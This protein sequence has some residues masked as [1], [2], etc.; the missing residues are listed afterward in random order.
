MLPRLLDYAVNG[1]QIE[2]KAAEKLWE[3]IKDVFASSLKTEE[4]K[5]AYL[6]IGPII[7][8]ILKLLHTAL[9]KN[10]YEATRCYSGLLLLHLMKTMKVL[11]KKIPTFNV[12][13]Q[14]YFTNQICFDRILRILD[15]PLFKNDLFS[16]H[17][18][19]DAML[20]DRE[21]CCQKMLENWH[22][23]PEINPLFLAYAIIKSR[24]FNYSV[25]TAEQAFADAK[26]IM[27]HPDWQYLFLLQSERL[28]EKLKSHTLAEAKELLEK[29]KVPFK[30]VE[31]AFFKLPLPSEKKVKKMIDD[32]KM[33]EALLEIQGSTQSFLPI[34][35]QGMPRYKEEK[36]EAPEQPVGPTVENTEKITP[37]AEPSVQSS[38]DE[39]PAPA[40][41][42]AQTRMRAG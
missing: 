41:T 22:K 26:K 4:E 30:P 36:T 39:R 40:Y 42:P 29:I 2:F 16:L 8:E 11:N 14:Y 23:L 1:G 9:K 31:C 25:A 10:H 7:Q 15:Q 19:F 24:E 21:T 35:Q 33:S 27:K 34:L 13:Q 12:L 28:L 6:S 32:L 5:K 38:Q 3:N 18:L 20:F 37:L 17:V